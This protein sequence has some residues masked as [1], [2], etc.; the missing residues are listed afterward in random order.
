MTPNE[1]LAILDDLL[2]P[3]VLSQIQEF[4]FL[5]TFAG[6]SYGTMAEQSGYD[7]D[8][9]KYVGAR[10]WKLLSDLLGVKVSKTN[11]SSAIGQ[12]VRSRE[13]AIESSLTRIDPGG[14]SHCRIDWGEATE[15]Y[16]FQGREAELAQLQAWI[17]PPLHH[18]PCKLVT[19][20]GMGGMG[21]TTLAVK[22][23]EQLQQS[24]FEQ[25]IWRSLRNAPP[26]NILLAD[27]L[28]FLGEHQQ[29]ADHAA[30][31]I[32]LQISE[33]FQYLRTMRCAIVLDNVETILQSGERPGG[34]RSGYEG[35]ETL[36]R[37]MGE[38]RH[39]SC[40]LLTSRER[41]R[42][43][44]L[45]EG[46]NLSVRSLYLTR[47]DDLAS[48]AIFQQRGDFIGTPADWNSII[49]QYAGNPLA[50]KIVA[51]AVEELFNRNLTK[52]VE[53]LHSQIIIFDDIRDLLDRQ[54]ARLTALESEVTMWLA[55]NR[56]F[57]TFEELQSDLLGIDAKRDL[58][59]TL[60]SL[61]RRSLIETK[62]GKFTLQPVVMEYITERLIKGIGGE[63]TNWDDTEITAK[64]FH[65]Y[66]LLKVTSSDYLK[67]SQRQT[68]LSPLVEY[69]T[70]DFQSLIALSARLR[71]ILPLLHAQLAHTPTYSIGNLVNLL[72]AIGADFTGLDFSQLCI[73][74]A[75]FEEIS[76]HRANFQ[77]TNLSR[78]IFSESLG[79]IF[80]VAFL[81]DDIH[82]I[83][84][85]SQGNV[86]R[87][88]RH[89]G[90]RVQV[91]GSLSAWVMSLAVSPD[92]RYLAAGAGSTVWVW[93]LD[94]GECIH[95]LT[96]HTGTW[97]TRMVF[98][99]DRPN[100]ISCGGDDGTVRVWD[101]VTGVCQQILVYPRPTW[102][103]SISP[104][105]RQIAAAHGDGTITL[106]DRSTGTIQLTCTGHEQDVESVTFSPD[107]KLL[108]SGSTD[109]SVKL[110]DVA[111]GDCIHTLIG[112]EERVWK[113]IFSPDGKTIASASPDFTVRLWNVA[114]A[115]CDRV[116][117]GFE[118]Y[119][120]AIDFSRDGRFLLTGTMGCSIRLWEVATGN[121]RKYWQGSKNI[122]WDV[123]FLPDPEGYLIAAAWRDCQTRVWQLPGS[124]CIQ[125]LGGYRE[126]E[127]SLTHI[128]QVDRFLPGV[129]RAIVSAAGNGMRLWNLDTGKCLKHYVGHE[130][131]ILS[132]AAT[133]DGRCLISGGMDRLVKIWDT[134]TGECLQTF[135][136]HQNW[137]F[138]VAVSP[139]APLAAS[140]SPDG[141]AKLWDLDALCCIQTFTG[142]NTR[143]FSLVFHPTESWLFTGSADHKIHIW[144]IPSGDCLN[145]I[146]GHQGRI[147]ALA[148]SPDGSILASASNDNTV[149][150]W[151]ARTGACLQVWQGH[152]QSIVAV[153][154][155]PDGKLVASSGFDERVWIWDVEMGTCIQKLAPER[156]YAGMNIAGAIGLTAAQKL[157]LRE[158]GAIEH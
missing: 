30:K 42:E 123:Q 32:S 146:V 134:L 115:K 92:G 37:Q 131:G 46:G 41:L 125:Q 63:L 60:E 59:K 68:I 126:W 88:H 99:G 148:V 10:L 12:Y 157:T 31:D 58:T 147:S 138:A 27:L 137:V 119:V 54:F 21:K 40:I 139:I 66:A 62:T 50:L 43:V 158:L 150:L 48:K 109:R 6:D 121:C 130:Q 20:V 110:W 114:T 72:V 129:T 11:L 36:L 29:T 98:D 75:N 1:A 113:T 38:S 89:T 155:S 106:W 84:G 122:A 127:R 140:A 154:F 90:Q 120:C 93:Q 107:G 16:G 55:I 56:E 4:V 86:C 80:S 103:C 156:L 7:E 52:F 133:P 118:D 13:E 111:T 67:N 151:N 105:G 95:T 71:Q 77:G 33:L 141:T 94:T 61:I 152:G 83:S 53:L 26:L 28:D 49:Q 9:I 23:V 153:A 117:K 91:Y 5:Q 143:L 51:A 24:G 135:G 19:I 22:L 96:E 85:D 142:P 47:L 136:D 101:L 132:V 149:R 73:W 65:R 18:P 82:F 81:P 116:L 3:K 35:Y 8:Y 145:T 128:P 100:L 97:I 87:W 39:Q 74:Q 124:E 15:L 78:S 2:K 79:A 104:D 44:T 17:V 144:D 76:L 112:H 70:A 108:V 69:L 45:L 34:Y 14:T 64:F 25:I 102:S 57:V